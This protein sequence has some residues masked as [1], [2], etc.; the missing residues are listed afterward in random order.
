MVPFSIPRVLLRGGQEQHHLRLNK[1][2]AEIVSSLRE[3]VYVRGQ[4]QALRIEDEV[5][6]HPV[7]GHMEAATVLSNL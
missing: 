2:A 5:H 1:T 7:G 3:R 6:T 4:T